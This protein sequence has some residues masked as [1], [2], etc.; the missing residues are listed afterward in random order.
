MLVR[1]VL[2]DLLR[3]PRRTLSTM[4]GVTLGVGLFCG[5]LFFVDGLSSSMTQRAVAPL[6]I[7]MQ[8]IVTQPIGASL[9]M[10][11]ASEPS[12][13]LPAS[14]D[15]SIIL[16]IVNTGEVEAHDVTVRSV[17]VDELAFAQASAEV[18]GTPIEGIDDNPFAHGQAHTG[19]NLG[20]LVPGSSRRLTYRLTATTDVDVNDITVVSTYSSRENPIP[21]AANEPV[22]VDLRQLSAIISE[23]DGVAAASPLSIADLGV[24]RLTGGGTTPPGPAKIFAFDDTYAA[25]YGSIDIVEGELSADGAVLSAEAATALGLTLGD[26]VSVQLPDNSTIDLVVTGVADLSRARSLFSSRR[27]GDLETFVYTAHSVVVSPGTFADVVQPAFDRAAAGAGRVKAP[28][29][30]EVDIALDRDLLNADPATARL[31]TGR[32]GGDVVA[33]AS[34]SDYLLDNVSNTLDVAAGDADVAKRLFLFLGVPGGFLAAMLAA[35]SGTVLAEAQRREQAMLRVRGAA[36]AHLLRMLALRTC[37]LTG[38]GSAIGLVSGYVL[39]A[40]ILGKESLDRANPSSLATSAVLGTVGGFAATGLALYLTGRRSIDRE[41]NGDRARHTLIVPIWRRARLDLIGVLVVV[42]GTTVAVR[43]GAFQGA[44]GS[45][46]F[47]RG[48]TLNVALLVLP[49][50]V[51]ITGSLLGARVVGALLGRTQPRSTAAVGR[52]LPSLYRLSIGRRP[53]SI[54]NGAFIVTLIVALATCL[55]AFTAS[56]DAAKVRD[57]RYANGAD[58]RI[59]PSPTSARGYTAEDAEVFQTRG[60]VAATPVVYELSNVILRSARTSDP[61]NLAA[62][63]PTSYPMV[64]PLTGSRFTDGSAQDAFRALRDDPTAILVSHDMA[65]FLRVEVGDTLQVVLA[66]ATDA[67]V[68][69]PLHIIAL[70]E[71][72]PGFPDGADAVMAISAHTSAVPSKNPDFFLARTERNDN[73]GLRTAVASLQADTRSGEFQIDTRATTLASD[74]SSLAALN[75]AGLVQLDSTFSLAMAVVTIAIFVFGLLLQRRR[76]YITL[77]AQGLEPSTIRRLITLEAAT[78]AVVGALAGVIVGVVMGS[79]FVAVLRPLFVL[80][81]NYAVPFNGVAL[82]VGLVLIATIAST[83]AASRMVNRLEPTELLRDE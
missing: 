55:A 69:I 56:Y 31:E 4:V 74:Q 57:A 42:V 75:I 59:T 23:V 40:A 72:L 15:V 46:Y 48:V 30:R 24:S 28:P 62:V 14:G 25:R 16:E 1:Y 11:Q 60:I 67:Q 12:G 34:P 51:W 29:I 81:P 18:D 17:P 41:I 54:S 70:F 21:V 7:D 3:N 35:Y 50:A 45:V 79:Y 49:L 20:T 71:R 78:V 13:Q 36:R 52:P 27:G 76:E 68:E 82:A 37:A 26:T 53:W 61:A 9:S 66:R 83:T 19:F 80:T 10:T 65:A 38:A 73:A 33:A 77:R 47:G 64:A 6:P 2:A 8:L 39:A 63:D 22:A 43:S 58:I 32:I 44:P 5:V